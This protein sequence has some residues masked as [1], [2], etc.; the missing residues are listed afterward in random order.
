MEVVH[1]LQEAERMVEESGIAKELRP[2][3]FA[4]AAQWLAGDSPKQSR[5]VGSKSEELDPMSGLA[6]RLGVEPEILLGVY[7]V[8][9]DK[10]EL[11]VS[12]QKF[13]SSR[14]RGTKQ[15]ALLVAAGRQGLGLEDWTL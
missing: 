5:K 10:V 12:S 1:I 11:V 15:I 4:L 8:E 14:A 7:H 6:Q 3:A 2:T 9:D 13:D